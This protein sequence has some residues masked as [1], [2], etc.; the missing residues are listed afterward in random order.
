M[1]SINHFLLIISILFKR[2]INHF[3]YFLIFFNKKRN[4]VI[5]YYLETKLN[6]FNLKII[7]LVMLFTLNQY[8]VVVIYLKKNI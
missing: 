1:T 8:F 4:V 6:I 2:F 7:K 3:S 5:A